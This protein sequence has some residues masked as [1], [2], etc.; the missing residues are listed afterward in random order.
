MKL[1]WM[2]YGIIKPR[3]GMLLTFRET[4]SAPLAG[5]PARVVD[6]W[7]RFRSGDYL[8]TLEYAQPVPL[9]K[10]VITQITAFL[11]ELQLPNSCSSQ[12]VEQDNSRERWDQKGHI[13]RFRH[14]VWVFW[15]IRGGP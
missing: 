8:V 5:I 9:G 3:L 7:P 14:D 13:V 2:T 4:A 6:I 15:S 1:Q 11:S 10:E 12:V